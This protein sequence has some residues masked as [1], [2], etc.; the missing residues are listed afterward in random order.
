[1]ADDRPLDGAMWEDWFEALGTVKPN[2]ELNLET[3]CLTLDEAY[4]TMIVFL[5]IY[6]NLGAED[7]FKEFV[8]SLKTKTATMVTW[9]DWLD[10]IKEITSHRPRIRS[11][12]QL[13]PK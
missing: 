7:A 11:Y 12:A 3:T 9:Q 5:E 13:L 6:C 2:Q 1:M 8:K 4:S 10:S